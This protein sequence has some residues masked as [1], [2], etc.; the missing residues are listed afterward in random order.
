[1]K[2]SDMEYIRPDKEKIIADI[3]R[4]T[5]RLAS[6]GSFEEADAA[7]MEYEDVAGEL[8]SM[9]TIANIRH[10]IDTA[11]SFYSD[12]VDYLDMAVPEIQEYMQGWNK[13][14]CGTKYRAEFEEKY[15]RLLFTNLEIELKTFS[16][17]IISDIQRENALVT[18][19]D[20]L[21]ASAQ[22]EFDGGVYTLSQLGPFKSDCDD[23]KRKRAWQAEGGFYSSVRDKL[24]EIFDELVHVRDAMAKKMGYPDYTRLGY[25]RMNRNC[26]DSED[27]DKFREAVK[28]YV[29]PVAEEL[30]AKQAERTGRSLPLNYADASLKFR[31]G[32]PKP[33]GTPE[34]ILESGRKFYHELSPETGAFIDFMMENEL[35]DV[36]SRKGKAG[37]GYC[38]DIPKYKSPFIFANF[39]GTSGDV[40]V[41]THEA[42]HA[43]AAYLAR[44]VFPPELRSPTMEA[45]EVHSMS[46]EFLAWPWEE[47]FFG[48]DAGRFRLAHLAD[49]ITFI[50]YG[51]MVDEF[52][53][54]VYKNPG[55]TPNERCDVWKD[56]TGIYMPWLTLD[57]EIPFYCD[58]RAWQRQ[59]HIYQVPFYYIDYCLAQTMALQVW[60]VQQEDREKAWRTYMSYTSQAGRN[61]FTDAVKNCGLISP[62][63]E[64]ALAKVC[65]AAERWLYENG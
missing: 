62:F 5:E 19:Y 56:L 64:S 46:M 15:G 8:S 60:A 55:M 47:S 11:D 41:I 12:E 13:Q 26:Y 17:D 53:H 29:V 4:A 25:Y 39:N 43:F 54:I 10:D 18:E 9:C 20:K 48:E 31:E 22:I 24:D 38:T 6:A 3:V 32:N 49:A 63:E 28:K 14:L 57:R 50:P 34:D 33:V 21:L 37:G 44:D 30:Y 7:L 51:T 27:V 59:I 42:G 52:Q 2:F 16:P 35:F 45:C 23:G 58:G 65:G 1:M 36:L 61:T 40:E